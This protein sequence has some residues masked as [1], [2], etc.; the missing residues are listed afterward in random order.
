MRFVTIFFATLVLLLIS[1]VGTGSYV[2]LGKVRDAPY[3][4]VRMA[5]V[6]AVP[7]DV[8]SAIVR[9]YAKRLPS[10]SDVLIIG[11]SQLYGND[12]PPQYSLGAYL[13]G[14]SHP[15]VYNMSIKDG[16]FSDLTRIVTIL[17]QEGKHFRHLVTSL[18]PTH[19]KRGVK[20]HNHL[21]DAD[22]FWL[23][24]ALI[25]TSTPSVY[26]PAP[27]NP[28]F[29]KQSVYVLDLYDREMRP[30]AGFDE[31]VVGR[32]YYSDLVPTTEEMME[33]LRY[34]LTISDHLV[35]FSAPASYAIYNQPR[36]DYG[37]N[38][39]PLLGELLQSCR[40]LKKATC[41]ELSGAIAYEYFM[42]VVH[43]APAGQERL[44]ALLSG[45]MIQ[46]RE[47]AE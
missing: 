40:T 5:Q 30:R 28:F 20:N 4:A 9:D 29:L 7:S 31:L 11:D 34:A 35:V 21:P 38:T 1:L 8:R 17:R 47:V 23:P 6:L 27:R 46:Q 36:Y 14:Q 18:N 24:T 22:G 16:R 32:D 3:D 15:L 37:W 26:V 41:L 42:D 12:L 13:R 10:V 19:F 43:L 45:A 39:G 25:T 44:A 2:L 33:F